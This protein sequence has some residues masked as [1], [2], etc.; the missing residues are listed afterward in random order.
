[1]ADFTHLHLHSEFSLLDG[2]IKIPDLVTKIKDLGMSSVALTDHG[3]MYGIYD[4]WMQCREQ[5]IKP[6]L[7]VEAYISYRTRFDKVPKVDDKRYHIVLLAKNLEGYKNIVK[8]VS[9]SHLEGFYYKPRIDKE[10]LTQ[11]GK[12]VIG[13]SACLGGIVNK[14]LLRGHDEEASEWA[15]FLRNNL[16]EFYIEVQRNGIKEAE[17]LV[18]KQVKFAS[19]MQLPIVASCDGHYLDKE[20]WF[21]QEV[22]WAISDGKKIDDDTRRKSWSE[23]FY[24][25]SSE[26]MKK[27]FSDIPEAIEN[28]QKIVEKVEDFDIMFERVQPKFSKLPRGKSAKDALRE[29]SIRGAKMRYG[30]LSKDI[31][32]RINYELDLIHDKGY[33]DYFLVV[34]DYVNWALDNGILVGPGRGSGAGSVVSYSL[35]IT[36]IDPFKYEL[37]F[38]RFLNPERPSP[39]DFDIDFQDDRRDELFR[40]MTDTYGKKNTAF[41][42]TFGRMKTRAAIR[43]VARVLD[44]DLEIA[45]K[46]SK[47]VDVKFGKVAHMEDMMSDNKEFNDIINSDS[48]LKKLADIV[49]R[50]EGISRHVSTHACGYLVTPRPVVD[51][52]PLQRESGLGD[53]VITQIEGYTIENVGL[54]KFDFLGLTNLTIIKNVLELVKN[55]REEDIDIN[56]IPLDD[57]A[58]Y[59]VFRR[60]LTTAVFQF[61]SDGMKKYLKELKP[62][63]FEDLIFLVAAYRPGP[64]QYI[65]DYIARKFGKQK[66][67]YL[68]PTLKPILENT[69]GFAIYQEQVLR[70]AVDVAGYSLGEADMLRRAMG[71]KKVEIMEKEREKFI[72][73]S[74]KNGIPQKT[75]EKIFAFVEPFADYGFNK[76]HAACYALISYQT[77]YLKAH[78]PVEFMAGLMQ[79]DLE[80][81]EKITRDVIEA[82]RMGIKVLS[83]NI[84]KSGVGFI[85]EEGNKIRFGLAAVKNVSTK[86][87]Q[88]IVEEREKTGKYENLDELVA[89]VGS[90]N[91]SKKVLEC[92]IKVG[93]M[94]QF[95]SRKALLEIMPTIVDRASRLEKK[96]E[97]GQSG[98]FDSAGAATKLHVTPLPEIDEEGDQEKLTWEKE[99]IG[100]YLSTHPLKKYKKYYGDEILS[101]PEVKRKGENKQVKVGG[102]ISNKREIMTR[103]GN[104]PMAFLTIEC[105]EDNIEAVVFNGIYEKYKDKLV[106]DK[107][108]V[109]IGKTSHREGKISVI[110]DD[111]KS[112]N[113][114]SPSITNGD[115]TITLDISEEKNPLKLKILRQMIVDNPGRYKLLIYYSDKEGKKQKKFLKRKISL[116]TSIKKVIEDYIVS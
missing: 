100:T 31:T 58:T 51:Y 53:R 92:L 20:D 18:E 106:T 72:K 62:S 6:I 107:P 23:E 93:A 33:D 68:H 69:Y 114:Y 37:Y 15:D 89:R 50:V 103:N 95:G 14:Q 32:E 30:K 75:A 5:E 54:M 109:F 26:E 47:M 78:Y 21:A 13:L 104:K 65:P 59:K 12:G 112:F 46:L 94:D 8:M 38:E 56:D 49:K 24:I 73:G 36:N 9:D 17:N 96:S 108:L 102:I 66:V 1:M 45:D 42:G 84:N 98:L 4:F 7:G 70:I 43:D 48:Q 28:T 27:L 25:K 57:N 2:L 29:L 99:L 105:F 55:F 41:I 67:E 11:Y 39:P 82:E 113:N 35:K 16:D 61:E 22:L 3:V 80:V 19:K 76:S 111:L 77:A 10:L 97:G 79:T 44:I 91:L 34:Q 64:M 86:I 83:P 101:V 81:S 52:I 87:V 88:R 115:D 71:K 90:E 60:G 74:M 63:S 40:Y 85:I 116:N 110:I